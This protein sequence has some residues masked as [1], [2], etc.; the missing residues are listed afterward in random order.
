MSNF[1]K[2]R[3]ENI[4]AIIIAC[5]VALFYITGVPTAFFVKI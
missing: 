5:I 1:L 4:I 2:E 3:K